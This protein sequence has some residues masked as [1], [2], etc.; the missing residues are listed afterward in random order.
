MTDLTIH[1]YSGLSRDGL[2]RELRKEVQGIRGVDAKGNATRERIGGIAPLG[3]REAGKGT[4]PAPC[5][6]V[7][8]LFL[9]FYTNFIEQSFRY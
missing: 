1:E 3:G 4:G 6:S 8:G 2:R 5:F 7:K 9:K